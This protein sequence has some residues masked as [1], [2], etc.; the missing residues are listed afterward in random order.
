MNGR[1]GTAFLI[2]GQN[3]SQRVI[4]R[5]KAKDLVCFVSGCGKI[6]CLLVA[7]NTDLG[8]APWVSRQAGTQKRLG[9]TP[10]FRYGKGKQV[11]LYF[12]KKKQCVCVFYI[13]GWDGKVPICEEFTSVFFPFR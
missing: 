2:L 4:L 6:L 13:K 8:D 10:S 7:Q 5:P 9:R 11:V 3:A 12:F 1:V